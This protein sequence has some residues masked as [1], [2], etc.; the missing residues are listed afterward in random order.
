MAQSVLIFYVKNIVDVVCFEMFYVGILNFMS[1][2]NKKLR[3]RNKWTKIICKKASKNE[4]LTKKYFF[5]LI[6]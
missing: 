6:E 2:L 5:N 4:F 1:N 3:T